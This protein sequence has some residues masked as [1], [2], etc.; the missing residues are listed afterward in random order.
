MS[1]N[2]SGPVYMYLIKEIW[3]VVIK[4]SH[5]AAL[6]PASGFHVYKFY[7]KIFIYKYVLLYIILRF[8]LRIIYKLF[9]AVLMVVLINR[10]LRFE[11]ICVKAKISSTIGENRGTSSEAKP[12]AFF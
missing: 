7:K 2:R 4:L 6:D 5:V 3:L 9:K 10:N 8:L 11:G 1:T 12:I